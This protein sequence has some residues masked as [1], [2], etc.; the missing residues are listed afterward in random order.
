MHL[1]DV[2]THVL[3]IPVAFQVAGTLLFVLLCK[4]GHI[5]GVGF[6]KFLVIF[7]PCT[8]KSDGFGKHA[9][10]VVPH[11]LISSGFIQGV[12]DRLALF[13]HFFRRVSPID[14]LYRIAIHKT[15]AYDPVAF[16]YG[17][18]ILP[19]PPV[20]EFPYPTIRV[21]VARPPKTIPQSKRIT[22]VGNKV[23]K[24]FITY[25]RNL[26]NAYIVILAAL[27]PYLEIIESSGKIRKL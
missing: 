4:V 5:I 12:Y 24:L 3:E 21:R 10:A 8:C 2:V 1:D 14:S 15:I 7:Q 13:I 22:V 6:G 20:Y 17:K 9:C 11:F 27:K 19:N 25:M 26:V 23:F 16:R 18:S